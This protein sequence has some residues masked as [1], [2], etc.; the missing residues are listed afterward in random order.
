MIPAACF[1]SFIQNDFRTLYKRQYSSAASCGSRRMQAAALEGM[2]AAFSFSASPF[3]VRR[4]IKTRS[5]FSNLLRVTRPRFSSHFRSGV[6]VPES[7]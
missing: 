5:S 3:C 2:S 4:T 6:N 7:R 1:D